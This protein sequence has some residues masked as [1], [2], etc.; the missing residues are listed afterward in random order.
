MLAAIK[1]GCRAGWVMDCRKAFIDHAIHP[2]THTACAPRRGQTPLSLI[3]YSHLQWSCSQSPAIHRNTLIGYNDTLTQDVWIIGVAQ[4]I[5]EWIC[6][7]RSQK[8]QFKS[9]CT[10]NSNSILRFHQLFSK[11]ILFPSWFRLRSLLQ[12]SSTWPGS[13]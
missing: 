10:L 2:F 5:W 8:K 3:H 11:S 9:I 7:Y 1:A 13:G 6:S 12:F 4:N